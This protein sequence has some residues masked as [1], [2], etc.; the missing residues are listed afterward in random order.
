MKESDGMF[1][2][3]SLRMD[4]KWKSRGEDKVEGRG[5]VSRVISSR[6]GKEGSND[7]NAVAV[8]DK[9]CKFRA[10]QAGKH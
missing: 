9:R 3:V 4:G 8:R 10:V 5:R 6:L 7:C 1:C 2:T